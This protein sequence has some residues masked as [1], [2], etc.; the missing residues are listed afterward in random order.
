MQT[1]TPKLLNP[2]L[3]E[4]TL[5]EM[6]AVSGVPLPVQDQLQ[7]LGVFYGLCVILALIIVCIP[8]L[9]LRKVKTPKTSTSI[10][11]KLVLLLLVIV[12]T[13]G[14][15][16]TISELYGINLKPFPATYRHYAPRANLPY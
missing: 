15:I 12:L 10:K 8:Y 5:E 11:T 6:R 13:F 3:R 7:I 1:P 9:I 16:K 14:L 2:A 4:M